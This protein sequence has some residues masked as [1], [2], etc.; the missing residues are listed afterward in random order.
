MDPSAPELAARI[1]WF[2]RLRWFAAAGILAA[3]AAASVAGFPVAWR[4]LALLAGGLALLNA[5]YLRVA[6]R[7]VGPA[8]FAATQIAVDLAVLTLALHYSG[9]IENPCVFFY[10]FHVIL[11]AILFPGR[12]AYLIAGLASALFLTLAGFEHL[13][14]VEHV[15]LGIVAW[16]D[17]RV[18]AG[19][20]AVVSSTLFLAAYFAASI[21]EGL[22]GKE[23]EVRRFHEGMLQ[24]EKMAAVGQLA[25]G[26]AHE[27]NTPLGSIAGYA[28]ELQAIVR[29]GGERVER[30]AGVIRSQTERCKGI[31]QSLLDFAR[32]GEV[33]L[34]TVDLREPLREAIAYLRFRRTQ[35]GIV[36]ETGLEPVPA[37][38]A[39]PGR[40]LQ[41]FLSVLVNAVDAM[42]GGG[43]LIVRAREADGRALVEVSDSG[44][45]ISEENLK[46]V[47]E[48][49]FTTKEP[50]RGTG[51]GLSLSYGIVTRLGGTIELESR[52]GRG[53]TVRISLPPDPG[54]EAMP[55][56]PR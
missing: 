38:R 27:L 4:P 1:R 30:Y 34:R 29:G 9:G 23:A 6:S 47:F 28:E 49:F 31:T 39:D 7:N 41:V 5:V 36:V 55:E 37:V 48:P 20:V 21:M 12:I 56:G 26:L 33:R 32:K 10:V 54:P 24:A 19:G 53:T 8:G 2:I 51:L 3:A 52:V 17:P 22:R 42:E 11:A 16:R 35:P 43:R 50:G 44:C 15:E 40:L 25:A 18:L 13:G 14:W 45:G 46:K